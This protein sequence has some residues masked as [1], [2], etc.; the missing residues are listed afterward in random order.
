[1]TKAVTNDGRVEAFVTSV[2]LSSVGVLTKVFRVKL[3]ILLS[4]LSLSFSF[5]ITSCPFV[6]PPKKGLERGR[7]ASDESW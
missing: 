5:I 2:S 4:L 7:G 3:L 6:S 1:M